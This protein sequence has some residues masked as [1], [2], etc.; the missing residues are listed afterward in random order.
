[1]KKIMPF[2]LVLLV[3]V[4]SS[5]IASAQEKHW[6]LGTWKGEIADFKGAGGPVRTMNVLEVG[7]DG[8][9][10]VAWGTVSAT[11]VGDVK[12]VV[13]GDVVTI[14]PTPKT[15]ADLKRVGDRLEGTFTAA[16]G[17]SYPFRLSRVVARRFAGEV[18]TS[19]RE[20]RGFDPRANMEVELIGDS[21]NGYL[22]DFSGKAAFKGKM[23]GASF[24]SKR[25]SRRGNP[26]TITGTV[27]GDD[28]AVSFSNVNVDCTYTGT[29]KKQP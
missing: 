2:F 13:I 22:E 23:D 28:M 4:S 7:A 27:T 10:Q 24:E 15:R 8:T 3:L 14:M 21:V 17:R 5:L 6:L 20:C 18:Q 12:V 29:L 1:M 9:A 16:N 11:K 26:Q 25:V 19:G